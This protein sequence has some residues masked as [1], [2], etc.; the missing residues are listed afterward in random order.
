LES[1]VLVLKTGVVDHV[2]REA[3]LLLRLG[4]GEVH[5]LF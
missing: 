5:N 2:G 4:F 3:G 1:I